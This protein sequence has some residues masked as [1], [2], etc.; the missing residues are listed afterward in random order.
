MELCQP[1]NV[2]TQASF[3]YEEEKRVSKNYK[4]KMYVPNNREVEEK[5]TD[6]TS[7]ESSSL[8]KVC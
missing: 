7:S 2:S 3:W 6:D 4:E 8:S 1:L 5:S